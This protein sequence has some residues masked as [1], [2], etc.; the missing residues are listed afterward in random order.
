MR[1]RYLFFDIDGTLMTGG[2]ENGYV[3]DSAREALV[4]L[5]ENGH[6]LSIATG[7]ANAMA[8]NIMQSLG[9]DNMVSDGGYG[10]TIENTL[11]GIRPLP[12]DELVALAREC[13]EKG[14]PWGLQVDDS[15]TRL[16]PDGR[17]LSVTEDTYLKTRVVPGLRPE[18]AEKIFKMYIAC[19]YPQELTLN[20]LKPLPWCRYHK[21]Y[22]FVEPT[23]KAEGIKEVIRHFHADV[24][25][26]I[27]FGDS[28]NDLSMFTDEWTNVAMGNAVPALK[29][30]ADYVTTDVD[31]DGIY[32]ACI[33]LHLFD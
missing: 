1:K 30:K 21:N 12:K 14:L 18:N 29:A 32:N 16:V 13:D 11:L 33:A 4:R 23:Y 9:F 31:H 10:I 7:R 27:V 17:F 3:P 5:R 8:R 19:E 22:F 28:E 24:R 15:D 6:F 26:V 25:D 20:A 2:Y